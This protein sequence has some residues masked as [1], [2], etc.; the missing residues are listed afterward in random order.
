MIKIDKAVAFEIAKKKVDDYA[1]LDRA[2]YEI[3]LDQTID[4]K[5]GW[6]FFYNSSIFLRAGNYIHALI[7][8]APLLVLFDGR[9]LELSTAIPVERALS[10]LRI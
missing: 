8:N 6:V 4:W 2:E 9:L 10:E 5:N 1:R 3:V 7:G